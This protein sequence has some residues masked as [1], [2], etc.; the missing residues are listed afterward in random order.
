MLNRLGRGT[1]AG[2]AI[3]LYLVT[4]LL[5]TKTARADVE[6][7]AL[8]RPPPI[9]PLLS[10]QT[11]PTLPSALAPSDATVYVNIRS[12]NPNLRLYRIIGGAPSAVCAGPCRQ[13]LDAHASYMIQGDGIRPTPPFRLPD[14]QQPVTLDVNTGSAGWYKA[15]IA[16][17]VVGGAVS[18]A[19]YIVAQLLVPYNTETPPSASSAPS[20]TT[21]AIQASALA[22][23]GI[24]LC[25]LLATHTTTVKN[26][27][28]ETISAVPT[29]PRQHQRVRLTMH[30]LE[31]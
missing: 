11:A 14:S 20:R 4:P 15:G 5:T 17:I 1:H 25:L 13:R 16:L 10:A 2:I 18:F 3:A 7:Q 21:I 12:A 19:D 31:F 28:G 27:E 8:M 9:A 30:G 24:G 26:D 23:A 6:A 29:T 22:I